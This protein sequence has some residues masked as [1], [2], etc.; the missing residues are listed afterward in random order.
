MVDN[1]R[2]FYKERSLESRVIFF[3]FYS[4]KGMKVRFKFRL[5]W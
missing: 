3:N 4:Y 1:E 2:F 5:I